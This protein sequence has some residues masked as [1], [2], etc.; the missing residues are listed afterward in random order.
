VQRA[1]CLIVLLILLALAGCAGPRAL[2]RDLAGAPEAAA[3][4]DAYARVDQVVQDAGVRDGEAHLIP[5]FPYLRVNRFLASFADRELDAV[6][7][8]AWVD[9][10]NELDRQGREVELMNLPA[11]ARERLKTQIQLIQRCPKILREHDFPKERDSVVARAR[12]PDDYVTIMRVVGAYPLAA[13]PVA[14]GWQRWKAQNFPPFAMSNDELSWRGEPIFYSPESDGPPLPPEVVAATLDRSRTNPLGI[15]DPVG[16]DLERLAGTFAPGF[17]ID[18]GTDA[19]RIG[20]PVWDA[21]GLPAVD[22]SQPAAFVRLAHT[23]FD[24]EVAAQL[25]YTSWFPERPSEGFFDIRGGQLDGLIFRVTL[26]SDG[27]PLVF[28]TI[29]ACGCYHLFFPTVA[30]RRLPLAQ[31]SNQD[32]RETVEIPMRAPRLGPRQRLVVRVAATSHYVTG[33]IVAPHDEERW[34]AASY[35]LVMNKDL[36]DAALRSMPLAGGD[37]RS[38]FGPD[39]IISGTERTERFLLWP[40]GIES[41][42]A[43]RQWGRHPTAFVGRRHFDDPYL[44][45]QAFDRCSGR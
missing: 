7:F 39:G 11:A 15:P 43:M 25:V 9:R 34:P 8:E 41:A 2:E 32:V 36:P 28:D 40:M 29:H 10:L 14:F 17:L 1:P 42:G 4:L 16:E 5:G 20:R 21:R 37:R 24:G 18:V 26:G 12:V 19:D 38:L 22:T 31:D 13:I 44:L 35:R 33:L 6:A 27:R 30:V 23:W 3:C 45:D